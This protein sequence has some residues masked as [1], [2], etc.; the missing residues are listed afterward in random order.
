[1]KKILFL[2]AAVLTSMSISAQVYVGGN[3]GFTSS[4]LSASG[5]DISG[6]SYKFQPE[7]GYQL[8][9]QFAIGINLGVSKGLC[10]LGSFN[11]SDVKGLL[12][13]T[14]S[15]ATDIFSDS[16]MANMAGSLDLKGFNINP[17]VRFTA[18]SNKYI[19]V[20]IDGTIGYSN[21]NAKMKKANDEDVDVV[22]STEEK[23][24]SFEIAVKPGLDVKLT[25]KLKLVA[26]FG[27][28]GYQQMKVKDTDAKVTRFGLDVDSSNLL[29]GINY[30]F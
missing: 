10:A 7:V 30:A 23:I 12:L 5:Q 14:F 13:T 18:F 24:N 8:N 19:D 20:F 28:L 21:I 2:V 27:F 29:F 3:L 17:Y 11:T 15:A 4:K 16:K 25:E 22:S 1:M 9:D 26:K 6:S